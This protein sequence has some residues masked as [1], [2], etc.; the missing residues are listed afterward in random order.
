MEKNCW[1]V[2]AVACAVSG[3]ARRP[4]ERP[5]EASMF[6]DVYKALSVPE[7]QSQKHADAGG[8]RITISAKEMPIADFVRV[9]AAQ[10][11]ASVVFDDQLEGHKVSIEVQ[12]TPIVDVFGLLARRLGVQTSRVGNVWFIGKLRPEDR[13]YLVRKVRRLPEVGLRESVMVLLSEAGRVAAY[14]DGLVVCSDRVE[15]LERVEG[16]L[17]EV[18]AARSDTWVVQLYLVSISKDAK[19][20]FGVDTT[21]L[22]NL[23]YSFANASAVLPAVSAAKLSSSFAATLNASAAKTGVELIGKPIFLLGDGESSSFQSGATVPVPK[24][25]VSDQGTVTTSGFDYVQSGV[26]A[27]CAIRESSND[28]AK[29]TVSVSVG[30]ITGYVESAPIQEKSTFQTVAVVGANGVYLLGSLDQDESDD[31]RTGLIPKFLLNHTQER[32]KGQVQVWAKVF[33]VAG[34]VKETSAMRSEISK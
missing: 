25:T 15:V 13:G 27:N 5:K 28:S 16:L 23:S 34:P 6:Q 21:A 10:Y 1:F 9:L 32:K 7:A 26:S 20:T 8:A 30:Q 11:G 19:Q 14:N 17:D 33:R 4:A 24:K 31:S 12:D 18:E 29:L 3:C 2:L 22:A